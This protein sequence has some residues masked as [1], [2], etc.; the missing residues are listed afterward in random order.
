MIKKLARLYLI[1]IFALW[2]VSSLVVGFH[3]AEG[4]RSLVIVGAGFT[5][6]HLLIGPI[7]KTILGP[8]NFLTLGFIGLVVDAGLLYLLSIYFPQVSISPWLF[9]GLTIDGL[10]L[11]P[12]SLNFWESLLVSAA[13]IN[14]V[15]GILSFLAE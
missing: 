14:L 12:I 5:F 9:N 7:V 8:I 11:Q 2:A 15:R 6:L 10:S 1:N 13:V 3:L 4:F